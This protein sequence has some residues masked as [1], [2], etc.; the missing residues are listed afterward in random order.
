MVRLVPGKLRTGNDGRFGW[1]PSLHF[2]KIFIRSRFR[3]DPLLDIP[4]EGYGKLKK[5][6]IMILV[7]E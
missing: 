2:P 1:L 7:F 6:T 4:L 3:K 5:D